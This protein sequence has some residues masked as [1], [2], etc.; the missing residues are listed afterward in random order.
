MNNDLWLFFD[1]EA[2]ELI[3]SF[4]RCFKVKINLRSSRMREFIVGLQNPGSRFCRLVQRELDLRPRC[5]DRMN[6]CVPAAAGKRG[7]FC[8]PVT[9]VLWRRLCL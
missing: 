2:K 4:A 5:K 3:D 1:D 9:P 6:R 8:T 7:C